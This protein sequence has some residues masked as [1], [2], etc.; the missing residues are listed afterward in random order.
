[1][2]ERFFDQLEAMKSILSAHI[3][4]EEKRDRLHSVLTDHD[5]EREFWKLL[6]DPDWLS[7]LH[8]AG[9]FASPPLAEGTSGGDIRF[10]N[11]PVSK[12]LARMAAYS[13]A[14]VAKI[15]AE[16]ETNNAS[17]IRDMLDA[18]LAM[19]IDVASSLVPAVCRAAKD[20]TLWIYFKHA[21]DLCVR[22][23]EGGELNEATKLAEV[24]FTP[25]FEKGREEPSRLDEYWYKVGL[26]KLVPLLAS[27]KAKEFMPKLCDWLKASVEAKK[28]VDQK[29][30]ADYSY[31][32]RPAIEEHKLN[33]T[34]DF[35]GDMVGF[36]RKGFE[37]AIRKGGLSL[38]EAFQIVEPYSY[39]VFRRIRLHLIAEFADKKL[40]CEAI[41][42]RELFDDY[43]CKHEYAKLVG[44]RLGLLSPEQQAEW[45]KWIDAG[46]KKEDYTKEQAKYWKFQKFHWV[47]RHLEGERKT[48]YE[49]MLAEHGEP[50]MA[51]L[52]VSIGD[53][54]YGYESPMT[55]DDL[56]DMTLE[57]AVDK[58]SLWRPEKSRFE[59]PS[60]VGL[61]S[62][63]GQ[64]IATAPKEFSAHAR[65]L[66]DKPAIFVR[67]FIN[68][69]SEAVK[70]GGEIDIPAVLDLCQWVI[71]QP[72][73]KR[74][75]PEQE[76]EFLVD[77]DWQWTRD[78]ISQLVENICKAKSDDAPRYPLNDLREPMWGLIKHLYRDVAK[79][80]IVHD[81]SK[82]D[83]RV[84]DYID[85]GTN[86][87]RGEAVGAALEYARWVATHKHIKKSD[88]KEIVPGGFDAMPEVREMLEWLIASENRSFEAL[89][90]IGSRIN[91]IY[92]I[93]KKW[94]AE[95]AEPIFQLEGIEQTPLVAQGWAAW[96]A[97]LIWVKPH[98]EFYKIF[99]SQFAYAV[100][101]VAKV[102]LTEHNGKQ[103]MYR[104]G[105]HLMLIY[106]RGQ[107]GLDDDGRLLRRFLE[108]AIPDIRRQ[109][110]GFVGK[111][112]QG[113]EKVPVEVTER[114][115]ALWDLYWADHGKKDA[116]EKPDAW[117]FGT[118]FSCG[119]FP[120]Q[121]AL[122]RLEEFVEV[123][124]T[125]ES[126][127]DI[128]EKLAEIT[129]VNPAKS[130]QILERMVRGDKEGWR[131]HGWIDSAEKIL[132][133]ALKTSGEAREQ[134]ENL[135]D[136]LGRRGYTDFGK[137]LKK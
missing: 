71:E 29:S 58:V 113:D 24:L 38:D 116:K 72:I 106:G 47:E 64:Y 107:L 96:N 66:K 55:V 15:F 75:T 3:T 19:P 133:Q 89:S 132:E 86:S 56:S 10:P 46:P 80:Y 90:V 62:T 53:T 68:Q 134:A 61:A 6:E 28:H 84:R 48:F 22:L 102:T 124:P 125:P 98:I 4:V 120:D 131:I 115:M 87:P 135:I 92:W 126:N 49:R 8:K 23:A 45:F 123:V 60:L 109:V 105:V 1:M 69:M 119:Q 40:V 16:I 110:I 100:E 34:Y 85:L 41:L 26:K 112:L 70:T 43:E 97:F 79:S 42:N 57:Q 2:S 137:L 118:W 11:W 77:K 51:D 54:R 78:D 65:I 121:W 59:E 33:S 9:S 114:F 127:L 128:A 27:S 63:F 50:E 20:G 81:I 103:P 14:E 13:P 82:D 117:L 74:T 21:S 35:A 52:N 5:V 25:T 130:V 17:V 30:G 18:A 108:S 136:H 12:Y 7:V 76:N 104:L 44:R 94:L 99:K 67:E 73:E 129:H 36:V 32:W 31:V 95:N 122:D 111:S 91:M 37:E 93:D 83:P 101:Q 39:L 88:G